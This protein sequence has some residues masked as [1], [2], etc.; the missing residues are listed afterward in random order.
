MLSLPGHAQY[1]ADALEEER[2][3]L[4][5]GEYRRRFESHLNQYLAETLCHLPSPETV[6]VLG[7]YLNDERDTESIQSRRG[8][9]VLPGPPPP[10]MALKSLCDL[11]IDGCPVPSRPFFSQR[12]PE[13][14]A[15]LETMRKWYAAIKSGKQPFSF[16]G[17]SVEYRFKPDG[18]WTT[19]PIA[20]PPDD[21]PKPVPPTKPPPPAKASAPPVAPPP[22]PPPEPAGIPW[23]WIGA[24]ALLLIAAL[25]R[26]VILRRRAG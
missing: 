15:N 26:L 6:K 5:P 10:L 20:H 22:P 19:T 11:G 2:A 21:A 1:F 13:H 16:K 17:Q 4:K 3:A 24:G 9:D 7:F 14:M 25:A 12:S 23:L 8:N 18:T